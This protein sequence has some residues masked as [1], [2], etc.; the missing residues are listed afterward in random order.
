MKLS[1]NVLQEDKLILIE[2][3]N[4]EKNVAV[5]LVM[6]R[7][8][9]LDCLVSHINQQYGGHIIPHFAYDLYFQDSFDME[10]LVL[11]IEG[12]LND[13]KHNK[14]CRQDLKFYCFMIEQHTSFPVQLDIGRIISNAT[15]A[16][17]KYLDNLFIRKGMSAVKNTN[18]M[19]LAQKELENK[20]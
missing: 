12:Y 14:Y 7:V 20:I 18:M 10:S 13:L 15:D 4:T 8:N 16:S 6:R 1:T 3:F 17:R 5:E 2:T 9:E 19:L 11:D